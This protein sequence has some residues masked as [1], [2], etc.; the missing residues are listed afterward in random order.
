LSTKQ[1]ADVEGG[2]LCSATAS[3]TFG[4]FLAALRSLLQ[5]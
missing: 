3:S 4:G 2:L 1:H 5:S